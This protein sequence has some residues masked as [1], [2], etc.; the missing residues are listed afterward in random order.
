VHLVPIETD[1]PGSRARKKLEVEKKRRRMELDH[2]RIFPTDQLGGRALAVW[3]E[4]ESLHRFADRHE[5]GLA[6]VPGTEYP[7]WRAIAG[8]K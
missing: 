4:P 5:Y 1:S 7:I 6:L 2:H 8:W 3:L